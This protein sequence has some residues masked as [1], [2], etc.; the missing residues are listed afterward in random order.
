SPAAAEKYYKRAL[1]VDP[2]DVDVLG[3]YAIFL[4][5]VRKSYDEAEKYYQ[6][7]IE[8]D[9]KHAHALC[10]YALFLETVRKQHDEAEKY[11]RR[12]IEVDPDDVDVLGSY[13]IF[14][15]DVR[16]SYDEAEKYY[17][18]A[19]EVDSD[20]AISLGNYA[21]L[22]IVMI[23]FDEARSLIKKAVVLNKDSDYSASLDIELQFYCYAIFPKEHPNSRKNI[24]QLL[25]KGIRSPGWNLRDVLE[26]AKKRK[27]PD[28]A[29]LCEF[30]RLITVEEE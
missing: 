10:A 30:E 21:K 6:R 13:A 5:D 9:P 28:Y 19:I 29:K 27:H 23:Q 7:A 4:S 24:K 11:F 8:A 14:L 16:K 20:D 22:K 25:A 15:S 18:R 2:D 26:V 3:S 1:E 17:Q 12:A